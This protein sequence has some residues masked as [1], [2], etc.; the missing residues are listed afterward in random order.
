MAAHPVDPDNL[1]DQLEKGALV[2]FQQGKKEFS[3]LRPRGQSC[4]GTWSLSD[5]DDHWR[6]DHSRKAEPLYHEGEASS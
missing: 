1:P 2:Q 5:V 6:F 3:L 4:C